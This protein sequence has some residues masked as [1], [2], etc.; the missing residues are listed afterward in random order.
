MSARAEDGFTL[1]ELIVSVVILGIIGG[2]ITGS[3]VTG[4]KV[5]DGTAEQIKESTDAQLA[6][7][8][9]AGDA[10]SATAVQDSAHLACALPVGATAIVSFSWEDPAQA[11]VPRVASWFTQTVAGER[12]LSRT[13]CQG[14]SQQTTT[15]SRSLG[16]AGPDLSCTGG[17][18]GTPTRT[19]LEVT[20]NSGYTFRLSGTRR[21]ATS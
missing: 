10:Q 14:A 13:F 1:P 11:A 20:E 2:A 18:N 21:A 9:F 5:T 6:S 7:A 3:I 4:L 15:V 8:Y 12:Q 16:A 19:T 17:C